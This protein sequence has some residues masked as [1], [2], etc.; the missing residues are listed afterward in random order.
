MDVHVDMSYCTLCGFRLLASNYLSIEDHV[1]FGEI[2]D[3]VCTA[4]VA[5]AEV[6]GQ[7]MEKEKPEDELKGMIEFLNVKIKEN[8]EL[9]AKKVEQERV[10]Q[11]TDETGDY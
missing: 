9:K 1:L 2:G 7:M 4:K 11:S 8:E 3:L 5:P 6:T 10:E